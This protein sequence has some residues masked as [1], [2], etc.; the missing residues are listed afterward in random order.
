MRI[1]ATTLVLDGRLLA[2]GASGSYCGSG[3]GIYVAINIFTHTLQ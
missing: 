2:D 1:E 3:G